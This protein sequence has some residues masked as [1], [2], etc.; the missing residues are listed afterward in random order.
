MRPHPVSLVFYG[1]SILAHRDLISRLVGREF[2]QR[3]RGSMLGAVWAVL[4]PL[5]TA[6]MFSFVFGS[7][8]Q[9]RWGNVGA[10]THADFTVIFL[11]GLVAHG[12]FAEAIQRAP[13]LV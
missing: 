10:D 11:T 6:L 2:T 13:T 5:L 8:F 7:V 12:I 1:R 3:F 9:S 4:T